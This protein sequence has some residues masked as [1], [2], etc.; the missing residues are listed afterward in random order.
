LVTTD[1]LDPAIAAAVAARRHAHQVRRRQATNADKD[2]LHR[3]YQQQ[4][5]HQH[6]HQGHEHRGDP[7]TPVA[8]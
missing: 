8:A 5:Q 4:G 1:S 6:Q 2:I 3:Q 7:M